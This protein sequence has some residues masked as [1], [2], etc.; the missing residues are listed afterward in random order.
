MAKW[1]A[2]VLERLSIPAGTFGSVNDPNG[3]QDFNSATD[4]STTAS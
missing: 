1:T 2:P 3:I 4:T